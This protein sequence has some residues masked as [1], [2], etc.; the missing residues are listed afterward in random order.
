MINPKLVNPALKAFR[1]YSRNQSVRDGV[2]VRHSDGS[3]YTVRVLSS[4]YVKLD[5][6]VMPKTILEF[7]YFSM[8]E[9]GELREI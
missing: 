6:K 4:G 5:R 9:S 2:E 7:E 8:I 1:S 3:V